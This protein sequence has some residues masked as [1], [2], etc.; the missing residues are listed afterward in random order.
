[1]N[2]IVIVVGVLLLHRMGSLAALQHDDWYK[3]W[4]ARLASLRWLKF[5]PHIRLPLS[6][7]IPV[8]LLVLLVGVL[9]DFWF[10][11]PLF[12]VSFL[13]FLYSLGRGDLR[14]KIEGYKDDLSRDA[15]QAAYHDA[16]KFNPSA[17]EGNAENWEQLHEEALGAISYRYFERYFAVMFWFA[18]A[19][20]PG[21]LLYRLL[22]LHSEASIES[23]DGDHE[24]ENGAVKRWLYLMEWLPVRLTGL[25]FAFVGNF[26][27]C[28]DNWRSSLLTSSVSTLQVMAGYV[29]AALQSGGLK[30]L[31][32][33]TDGARERAAELSEMEALFNRVLIFSLCM[34]AFWVIL[35]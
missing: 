6:L 32:N 3:N 14:E 31:E 15:L 20:A 11:I 25:S 4:V 22:V 9:R 18:L 29:T 34:V 35:L 26:T 21:A 17:E 8:L 23:L 5:R 2:F 33:M 1:M 19:G 28:L 16:A 10:G 24:S 7:F 27:A 12:L 30:T 13:V